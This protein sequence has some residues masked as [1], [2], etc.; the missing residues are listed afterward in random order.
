M[1][2]GGTDETFC[3]DE[4]T[5]RKYFSRE[6]EY[7]ALFI[8]GMATQALVAKMM[9]GNVGAI[10]KLLEDTGAQPPTRQNSK[11]VKTEPLGKKASLEKGASELPSGWGDLL[12]GGKPVN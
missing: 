7:G 10:K 9:D 12:G 3:K 5:L 4:K 2:M 6:L 11:P 8:E 1:F